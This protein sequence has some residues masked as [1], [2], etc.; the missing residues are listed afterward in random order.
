M[1]AAQR[2]RLDEMY[3]TLDQIKSDLES[4]GEEEREK[5]DNLTEGLQSSERGQN[6]ESAANALEE[7]AS[8]LDSALNSID[9]ARSV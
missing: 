4:M 8:V 2:K 9:E 7:A 3:D 6:L 5:F 1:N